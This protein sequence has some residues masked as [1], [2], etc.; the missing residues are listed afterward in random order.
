MA[1]IRGNREESHALTKKV[2]RGSRWQV[3]VSDFRMRS[4]ITEGQGS[5]KLENG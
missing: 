3:D 2:S 5:W 4:E 1:V